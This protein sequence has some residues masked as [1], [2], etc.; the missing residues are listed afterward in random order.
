MRKESAPLFVAAVG[1][2]V[3]VVVWATLRRIVV[4]DEKNGMARQI[5]WLRVNSHINKTGF[6]RMRVG[7][8]TAVVCFNLAKMLNLFR[9][10]GYV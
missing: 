9:M 4:I 1:A 7:L 3:H 10:R 5:H 2:P 8:A 6:S